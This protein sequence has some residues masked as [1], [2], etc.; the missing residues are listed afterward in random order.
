MFL[1]RAALIAT[2]SVAMMATSS[3][4]FATPSAPASRST[5]TIKVHAVDF[6]GKP[7]KGLKFCPTK[8]KA[9]STKTTKGTLVGKCDRTNS[10]GVALLTKV[11][12]G[13]RWATYYPSGSGYLSKKAHVSA[14]HTT[15]I[16][17]K[18][19]RG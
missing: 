9:D 10:H 14:G 4:A 6:T 3:V 13:H 18:L 7:I 16:K 19:A 1:S 2:T 8:H 5:G 15:K 17:W 11:K 12:P